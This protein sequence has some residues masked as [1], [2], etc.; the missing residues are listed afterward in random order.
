MQELPRFQDFE[1]KWEFHRKKTKSE[2]SEN[3]EMEEKRLSFCPTRHHVENT[4]PIEVVKS[5]GLYHEYYGLDQ[6]GDVMFV[7]S[8]KIIAE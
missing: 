5:D 6:F 3:A 7:H 4:E 1:I 2:E 8:Q